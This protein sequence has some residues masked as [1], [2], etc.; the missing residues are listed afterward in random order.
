MGGPKGLIT[1]VQTVNYDRGLDAFTGARVALVR[2]EDSFHAGLFAAVT[3]R[4]PA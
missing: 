4:E 2:G 3:E 1:R